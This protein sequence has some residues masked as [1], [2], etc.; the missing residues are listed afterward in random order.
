MGLKERETLL[1]LK[2]QEY[3][4]KGLAFDGE[5]YLWDYMYYDRMFVE[6]TLNLDDNLVKEY[7]PVE[8][9]VP[10]ILEIYQRLLGVRFEEVEG[11][12]WHPG[13]A[14]HT[15]K[16]CKSRLKIFQTFSNSQSGRRKQ[17][18]GTALL[19]TAIWIFSLEVHLILYI[20][21]GLIDSTA[22]KFSHA[23]IW[24]LLPGY[25]LSDGGRHYPITA[26]VAN[27]SKPAPNK[28]TLIRHDDVVTFFHEMGHAFHSLLSRTRFARFHGFKFVNILQHLP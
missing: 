26:M 19:V 12:L 21:H 2:E 5:F 7:F 25:E 13:E 11:E 4:E 8:F 20:A 17:K 3:K 14:F 22:S 18:T 6:K 28:P 10:T 24:P 1:G 16:I 27:L 15:S 23:A 9:V